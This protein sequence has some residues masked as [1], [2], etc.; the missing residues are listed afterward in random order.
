MVA[1]QK[2]NKRTLTSREYTFPE[3]RA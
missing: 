3:A 2:A 1:A